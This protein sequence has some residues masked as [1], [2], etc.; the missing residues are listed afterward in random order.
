MNVPLLASENSK[1]AQDLPFLTRA[2]ARVQGVAVRR[3]LTELPL[4]IRRQSNVFLNGI[5]EG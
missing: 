3:Q 1:G 5:N 4:G 2:F